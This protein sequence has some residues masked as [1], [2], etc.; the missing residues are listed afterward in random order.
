MIEHRVTRHGHDGGRSRGRNGGRGDRRFGYLVFHPAGQFVEIEFV[1]P[2]AAVLHV[3]AS[4]GIR[5]QGERV[6]QPGDRSGEFRFFR[7]GDAGD[8]GGLNR[9][10]GGDGR[11]GDGAVGDVRGRDP[12]ETRAVTCKGLRGDRPGHPEAGDFERRK[13]LHLLIG[14]DREGIEDLGKNHHGGRGSGGGR[15]FQGQPLT[16]GLFI[17]IRRR[18]R[19]IYDVRRID[20]IR[21]QRKIPGGARHGAAEGGLHGQ[22]R[23]RD[24]CRVDRRIGCDMSIADGSVGEVGGDHPGES[25]AVADERI[26]GDRSAHLE[27]GRL[28]SRTDAD[29]VVG[30]EGQGAEHVGQG[31]FLDRVGRQRV[32]HQQP[33]A[34]RLEVQ[35]GGLDTSI[36]DMGAA[37]A[38]VLEVRAAHAFVPQVHAIHDVG[39]QQEAGVRSRHR[40]REPGRLRKGDARDLLRLDSRAVGDGFVA[41]GPGCH[42]GGDHA[43]ESRAVSGEGFRDDRAGHG[44]V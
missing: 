26:G 23:S 39:A 32:V 4:H 19:S 16:H 18:N 17:E 37:H 31:D 38:V 15:R 29:L 1:E 36:K 2:D 3:H 12:G 41:N 40:P 5:A 14:I 13:D 35:L 11:V 6:A 22:G 34:Q 27:A 9:R 44:E 43:G 42:V 20:S 10:I 7:E 24:L 30:A 8:L 33:F 28:D 21:L 25:G